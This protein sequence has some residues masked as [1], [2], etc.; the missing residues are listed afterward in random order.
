MTIHKS[1]GLEFPIVIFPCD[2]DIYRELKPKTWLKIEESFPELMVNLNKNIELI[3]SEGKAIYQQRQEELELDNFNLLY[4]ALTRAI[5]QLY[6]ITN[7][8]LNK[9][10]QE[11]IRF[12]SGI[13]ISFLKQ[14]A[15]WQDQQNEYCFGNAKRRS[16]AGNNIEK[17]ER[18]PCFI[19]TPWK[20]HNINLLAN[21]STLW[22]TLRGKAIDYGDLIHEMMAKI[23][24]QEDVEETLRSYENK[25]LLG[26]DLSKKIGQLMEKIVFHRQ[27]KSYYTD[28]FTIYNEREIIG[29]SGQS[30]IPDRLAVEANKNITIIDYKTGSPLLSHKE[31]LEKYAVVLRDV[32]F[33]VDK[34]IL[35]YI[36]DLITVEEF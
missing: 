28:H 9:S 23:Q 1:K 11:N 32:G 18:N 7:K 30:I 2:L 36:N 27:L 34:K 25:G 16:T 3:G 22:G 13:F 29:K 14:H 15:L 24:T 20:D 5:E 31:Q 8:N 26:R 10:G 33:S 4:V 12:Y 17:T 19:S 21:S 35:V 6:I